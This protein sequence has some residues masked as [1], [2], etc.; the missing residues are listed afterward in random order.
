MST[1]TGLYCAEHCSCPVIVVKGLHKPQTNSNADP[2]APTNLSALSSSSL[3]GTH[4]AVS[5]LEHGTAAGAA[6]V[7]LRQATAA[8][9]TAGG[10][11]AGSTMNAGMLEIPV[12]KG[13]MPQLETT[14]SKLNMMSIQKVSRR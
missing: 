8:A 13:V 14:M 3:P 11:A 2:A 1:D 12:G 5:I 7:G 4:D 6:P 10:G 9:A